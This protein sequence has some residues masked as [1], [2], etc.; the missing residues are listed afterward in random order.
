MGVSPAASLGCSCRETAG[1]RTAGRAARRWTRRRRSRSSRTLR[2]SA[3]CAATFRLA[4]AAGNTP[5]PWPRSRPVPRGRDRAG[6]G[7]PCARERA[8]AD[9]IEDEAVLDTQAAVRLA[10]WREHQLR[11]HRR[12]DVVVVVLVAREVELGGQQL[13]ARGGYLHVDMR[14]TPCVPAR[15]VDELAARAV[16]GDLIGLGL[17]RADLEP[18]VRSHREGAA[19]VPLGL[20]LGELGV[21]A[22]VVAVPDVKLRAVERGAVGGCDRALPGQRCPRLLRAHREGGVGPELGRIRRVIGTLDRALATVTV[23]GG[24]LLY[25]MLHPYVAEQGP[26]AV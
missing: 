10:H 9:R 1:A 14:G 17:D 15:G 16:R 13:V 26:L 20:A 3:R 6:A 5:S 11:L 12:G 7:H 25:D 4:A 22:Q 19:Q 23:R 21:K 18:A 8:S 2:R 24:H